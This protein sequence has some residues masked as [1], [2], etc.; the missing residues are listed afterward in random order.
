MI[1]PEYVLII[2]NS[3]RMLAQAAKNVGLKPIVID[4]YADIDTLGYAYAFKQVVSLS[5]QYLTPAIE[6]FIQFYGVLPVIYGSGF[7]Y[8]PQSLGYLNQRLPVFGNT[9]S[10]FFKLQ[11]KP[12]FF[13]SLDKLSIPY[14]DISFIPPSDHGKWLVKPM[15]GQGGLGI[16]RNS[17]TEPLGSGDYW[18]RFQEGTQ[19]SVLFLADKKK[20]Q[21]IGFNT[22]WVISLS[23]SQEFV[24][25]GVVNSSG[26][27][28]DQKVL[29]TGWLEKLVPLFGLRGLNSL[30]FIQ[31]GDRFFILEINP[32]PSAS[33]QLYDADLLTRHIKASQGELIDYFPVK[34]SYSGYQI[35]YATEDVIIPEGFEWPDGCMDLPKCGVTC[36]TG[37]PI[38]SIIAHQKRASSVMNELKIKQLNLLKGFNTNGI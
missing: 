35:V 9:S 2:A 5:E 33:M 31:E 23:A 15:Q 3:G 19:H 14:P 29:I 34:S 25:S 6:Y 4:I 26:L 10:T 18:Q 20:V 7:E 22:Q 27:Q 24:F 38:C 13:T 1:I 36:R 37:Q 21:V 11:N 8:Y 28:N 17:L 12:Y 32:R 16:R 30:D